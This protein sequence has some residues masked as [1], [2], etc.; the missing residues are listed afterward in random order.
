MPDENPSSL[1]ALEFNLRFPGQ[2]ADKETNLYY[3]YFRDY[4]PVL[5]R[6]EQSDP[7]GL[8]GGLNT[9]A[10]VG[11]Q[12]TSRTDPT[13][14]Q[15]VRPGQVG[16]RRLPANDPFGGWDKALPIPGDPLHGTQ[17]EALVPSTC[18]PGPDCER[19]L[20]DALQRC[21][22]LFPTPTFFLLRLPCI[23]LA[24]AAYRRCRNPDRYTSDG[25]DD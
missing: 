12:V 18:Y 9:Y 15:R 6:Y 21:A 23:M 16:K 7:I 1:G 25:S 5:G 19:I 2:Y 13:G 8:Y 14:L 11:S 3:N 22:Q 17:T 10:Y 24:N 20:R 4:D